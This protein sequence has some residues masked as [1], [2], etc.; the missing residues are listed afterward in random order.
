[1][2][3]GLASVNGERRAGV[4]R[5]A[6]PHVRRQDDQRR[7][8]RRRRDARRVTAPVVLNRR[9]VSASSSA[10]K[11]AL[12]AIANARPT[13]NETF[14]P[15]PPITAI[16]DRDRRR[17]T[18]AAILAT[19]TSSFSES[20]PLRMMLDQMSCATAP[21]ARQH[22]PRDD[23]EDRRERDAR[24]HGEEQ[25]AAERPVA[26]AEL[27]RAQVRRRE[28]A[29]G[30]GRLHAAL[31]QHGARAEAD[32]RRQQVEEADDEHRPD[33]RAARGLR[34]RHGEEAHQDVRQAGRAEHEREAERD[35]VDRRRQEGARPERERRLGGRVRLR[36]VEQ[37]D[38]VE[39]DLAPARTTDITTMPI[40]SSTA[41]MICT[42]VVA[43]MPPKI[44]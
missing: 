37:L 24:D 30:A 28:V 2:M 18:A 6:R 20:W 29:A 38:R 4:G 3:P 19:T 10:G 13:M 42:H 22:E 26:A 44:T 15:S 1:M 34:V 27:L 7:S 16:D 33:D 17:S 9:Q 31:A 21:D 11:F 12:A 40:I 25:V 32:E 41:L 36:L 23:R 14:R 43:S 35:R 8:P 39:A 5:G